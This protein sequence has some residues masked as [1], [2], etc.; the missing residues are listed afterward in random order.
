[1][2]RVERQENKEQKMAPKKIG[3]TTFGLALIIFGITIIV[4]MVLRKDVFQYVMQ[5]WPL[6][7]V[8]L[9]IEVLYYNTKKHVEVKYD[10]LGIFLMFIVLFMGSCMYFVNFTFQKW[11]DEVWPVIERNEQ[12]SITQMYHE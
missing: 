11:Y 12:I 5:L 8:S 2:E 6:V 10:V 9:G 7:L 3:R 4:Q 1:M